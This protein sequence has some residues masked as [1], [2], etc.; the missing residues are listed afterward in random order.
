LPAGRALLV[1]THWGNA[2][3][4][5]V[6]GQ[7]V[8]DVRVAAPH[9]TRQIA[10][11][12]V[13][14]GDTFM[15]QPGVHRGYD[16]SCPIAAHL[17]LA[18][19]FN[20]NHTHGTSVYTEIIHADGTKEMLVQDDTWTSDELFNPKYNRFGVAGARQVKSGDVYHTHCEWDNPT[21]TTL[22]FPTEMCDGG[23]FYFP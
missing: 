6:D 16:V 21:G 17:N 13:N 3:T 23:S 4:Q 8:V 14:N 20:H 5:T 10:D 18:R 15:I 19:A 7:A 9:G 1:N 11:L 22:I 12:F 2:T